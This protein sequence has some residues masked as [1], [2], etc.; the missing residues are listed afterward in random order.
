[1]IDLKVGIVYPP[2]YIGFSINHARPS[3]F[4]PIMKG[5]IW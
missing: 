2:V 5:V 1:L 3:K 4:S